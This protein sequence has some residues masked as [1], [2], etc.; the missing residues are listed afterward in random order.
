M[1]SKIYIINVILILF[2]ISVFPQAA[3]DSTEIKAEVPALDDFHNVIYPIWHVAYPS[4]DYAALRSYVGDIDKGA[5][6]I[7]DA[8]LPGILQDKQEMWDK[9]V[10]E[11]KVAAEEY[12]KIAD[13]KDDEM[14][15]KAAENLHSKYESLVHIIH[16]VLPELD[17]FHQVLYMIY[18]KYLP[19]EDYQ[20]IYLVSDD[21]VKKAEDLSKVTLNTKD[22]QLQKKFEKETTQLLH[23]TQKLRDQ[24]KGNDYELVKY[25]VEDVHRIYQKI[26]DLFRTN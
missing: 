12:K 19:R 2:S 4:K 24:S 26:E 7:Y 5:Q 23:A 14:L 1:L 6:K 18:H 10:D 21:L 20:Q 17:Q 15:L 13:G 9:G 3:F 25:G 11:F 8:K 22:D 16:P